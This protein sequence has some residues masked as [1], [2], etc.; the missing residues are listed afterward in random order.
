[1]ESI[2]EDIIEEKSYISIIYLSKSQNE[3]LEK[4]KNDKKQNKK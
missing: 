4:K 1:M 2:E 3:N